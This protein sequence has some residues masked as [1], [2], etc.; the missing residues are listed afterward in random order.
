V[1]IKE[2]K[3]DL[4][5]S[6]LKMT[7]TT[8]SQV[9]GILPNTDHSG[10]VLLLLTPTETDPPATQLKLEF[11]I[12]R[13]NVELKEVDFNYLGSIRPNTIAYHVFYRVI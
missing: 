5:K 9:L 8:G 2:Y 6:S 10:A 7:F 13:S 11:F 3:L 1:I 12:Y 4:T